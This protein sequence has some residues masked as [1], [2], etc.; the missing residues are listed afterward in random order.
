MKHL[1]EIQGTFIS[2]LSDS[3]SKHL[4]RES[5]CLGLA[6]CRGLVQ[7]G[8]GPDEHTPEDLNNRLLRA[9]GQTTSFA[10]SALAETPAQAAQRR[11][12][13]A[14]VNGG[15]T[16]GAGEPEFVAE[17]GGASGIGEAALG[18]YR[19]MASASVSLGR[20]DI[21][22][23]LLILSV[24]HSYWFAAETRHRYR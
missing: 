19:E 13:E 5:C 20:H 6:A 15:S 11:L 9:F 18:A 16:E 12:E 4:S 17:V 1:D 23:A 7:S 22:Y 10:G 24:S 2:L 21:L 14:A 3:K 8:S